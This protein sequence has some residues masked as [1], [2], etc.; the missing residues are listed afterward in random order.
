[1]PSPAALERSL[2]LHLGP[3]TT[4]KWI[5]VNWVLK[6]VIKAAEKVHYKMGHDF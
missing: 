6:V 3:Q 2:T 4:L 1:M 5:T